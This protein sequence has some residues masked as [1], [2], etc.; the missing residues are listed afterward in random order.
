MSVLSVWCRVL[1]PSCQA[2]L[3]WRRASAGT[4]ETTFA[5]S[6]L[7]NLLLPFPEIP[8]TRN[9]QDMSGS[10]F[11]GDGVQSVFRTDGLF[12]KGGREGGIIVAP[13]PPTPLLV[14]QALP[15][16]RDPLDGG[17]GPLSAVES[18]KPTPTRA[19]NSRP[20]STVVLLSLSRVVQLKGW[21]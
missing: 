6:H 17:Q 21:I 15:D 13:E 12:L 5:V 1:A 9:K 20:P 16:L 7:L 18:L 4:P 2:A 10:S 19:C 14:S 8:E 11:C 3:G